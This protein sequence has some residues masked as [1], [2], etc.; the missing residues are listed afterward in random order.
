MAELRKKVPESVDGEFFVDTTCINCDTCRQLAPDTFDDQGTYSYVAR[1]PQAAGTERAALHAL[2]ACP[3]GSIGTRGVSRAK[4]AAGDF[5]LPIGSPSSIGSGASSAADVTY[6]GFTSPSSFGASSYFL[7]RDDGNWLIDSP[8]FTSRLVSA[9]EAQGGIARIF[10]SHRD[11]VAD[12]ARYAEHFGA[13]R[14]IHASELDAQPGAE[15][16]IEGDETVELAPGVVCI[17]TPGHTRGHCV[18]SVDERLLLSG[19]HLWWSRPRERLFASR[20]V[21]WYSWPEQ[22]RSM[23]RLLDVPFEWLLPGHGERR[24]LTQADRTRE[25]TRLIADMRRSA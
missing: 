18:L 11:D 21:C 3:T 10:L 1:Q 24:H 22:T 25:L 5:P 19:D 7:R 4:D 16:V 9:F 6:C 2:L 13:Q 23:E 17:P 8:R 12:A 15:Q 14:V 20:A